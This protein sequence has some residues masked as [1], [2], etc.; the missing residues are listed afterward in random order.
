MKGSCK[1]SAQSNDSTTIWILTRPDELS[2]EGFEAQLKGFDSEI[3][4]WKSA[5]SV[6][7]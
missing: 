2:E 6:S 7:I 1:N 5:L 4:G 3:A